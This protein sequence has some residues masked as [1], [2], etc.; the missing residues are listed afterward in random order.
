LKRACALL[1]LPSML[2]L[3]AAGADYEKC[4]VIVAD[5]QR[6][7]CYD[8]VAAQRVTPSSAGAEQGRVSAESR[9]DDLVTA[10]SLLGKSW[11][12]DEDSKKGTFRFREHKPVYLLPVHYSSNPN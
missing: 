5:A 7:A 8:Q 1:F 6:L 3:L 9:P 10:G 12:L 4:A 2:P 11:E